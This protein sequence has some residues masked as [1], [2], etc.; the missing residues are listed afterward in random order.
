[1]FAL[2]QKGKT[3]RQAIEEYWPDMDDKDRAVL[4]KQ[5]KNLSPEDMRKYKALTTL[6]NIKGYL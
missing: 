2:M 6:G 5:M 3:Y 4:Y 1:M